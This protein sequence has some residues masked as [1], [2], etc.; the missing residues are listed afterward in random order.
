MNH[1]I[2]VL[3]VN[4]GDLRQLFAKQELAG[5]CADLVAALSSLDGDY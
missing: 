1:R 5:L 4:P 3:I 2:Y